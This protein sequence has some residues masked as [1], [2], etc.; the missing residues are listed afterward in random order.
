MAT[1]STASRA[2]FHFDNLHFDDPL[3]YGPYLVMQVGDLATGKDFECVEHVQ[4]VHEITYV[5]N[6]KGAFLCDGEAYQVSRGDVILNRMG[7]RHAI[8][9]DSDDPI[10]YFY[11]GFIIA[12][13]SNEEEKL[14]DEFL[15]ES[16]SVVSKGHKSISVAFQDIFNNMLNPDRFSE[17]LTADAVRKLIVW[18]KRSFDLSAGRF[19]LPEEEPEKNR[20]LSEI[21]S[22]LD[23][24]VEDRGALKGLSDKFSYSYSYLSSIFSKSMGMSLREYFLNRR[25]E[26]EC[27]LLSQ[28]NS[29]TAVAETMGY[30]S[31]H[32][33]SHAFS[34]RAGMPPSLYITKKKGV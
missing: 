21:C 30:G 14:L 10:R 2:R 5:V 20:M 22:Y 18:T 11:I 23:S 9:G 25:F 6:G 29:V 16:I 13:T 17:R 33:F 8:Y 28:G 19:Y 12:D 31:V 3:R 32:S 26:R 1:F 4:A 7:S 27:E 24:S 34:A 15:N